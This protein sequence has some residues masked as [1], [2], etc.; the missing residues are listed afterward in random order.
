MEKL[1]PIN[2][3]F[4]EGVL[5]TEDITEEQKD[6][7]RTAK[8]YDHDIEGRIVRSYCPCLHCADSTVEIKKVVGIEDGNSVIM[9]DLVGDMTNRVIDSVSSLEEAIDWMN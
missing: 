6:V 5:V 9:F 8:Q 3:M 1:L 2:R 7:I 4:F